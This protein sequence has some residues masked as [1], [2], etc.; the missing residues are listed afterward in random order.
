MSGHVEQGGDSAVAR[1]LE[2]RPVIVGARDRRT[3]EAAVASRSQYRR[4]KC[5]V[6]LVKIHQRGQHAVGCHLEDRPVAAG[7]ALTC[8]AVK[9][10]VATQRQTGGRMFTIVKGKR[11][12]SRECSGPGHFE[13]VPTA[14]AAK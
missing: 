11:G 12:E 13:Y 14:V 4:R 6:A 10:T 2:H 3:I 8:G 9:I 7:A 5:P 1:H